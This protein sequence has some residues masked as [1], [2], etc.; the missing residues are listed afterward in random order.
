L[1]IF[2]SFLTL[3]HNGTPTIEIHLLFITFLA[4]CTVNLQTSLAVCINMNIHSSSQGIATLIGIPLSEERHQKDFSYSVTLFEKKC[5][6]Q[7]K[8]LLSSSVAPLAA[9]LLS[10]SFMALMAAKAAQLR[11]MVC[12]R[13][14]PSAAEERAEYLHGEILRKRE[15]RKRKGKDDDSLPS[16]YLKVLIMPIAAYVCTSLRVA[17]H[18]HCLLFQP[19]FWFPLLFR[20]KGDPPCVA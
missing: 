5:L 18:R 3:F 19:R 4:F 11:L 2:T 6:P 17:L 14:F 16:L 13:F 20:P 7:P 9:I 1:T 10:L 15:G 12:E 8:L